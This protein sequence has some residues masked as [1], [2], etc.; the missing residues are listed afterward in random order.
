MTTAR[1]R[2]GKNFHKREE[3][4][5]IDEALEQDLGSGNQYILM[6]ILLL[7][8]VV[9]GTTFAWFCHAQQQTISHLTESLSGLQ[10]KIVKFQQVQEEMRTKNVELPVPEGFAERLEALEGAY[11]QAQKQ[12]AMAV[13]T[14]EQLKTFDLRSQVASMHTEMMVRLTD[15]ELTRVS[16]EDLSR[17]RDT[18]ESKGAEFQAVKEDL[19]GVASANRAL[20]GSVEG[21]SASF[22][23]T[24]AKVTEQAAL[25]DTLTAQLEAQ[26]A[27]L[28]G[29]KEMLTLHRAQLETSSK[30]IA[31]LKGL[32][33]VEQAKRTH[34]L[35]E[36]L[37]FVRRSLE[38]QSQ[39]ALSLHSSLRAQ[40]ESIQGQLETALDTPAP[41][42]PQLDQPAVLE[43]AQRD[44]G[45][46]ELQQEVD[47]ELGQEAEAPA[48][49]E[50]LEEK[51]AQEVQEQQL[52]QEAEAPV[53]QE[54]QEQEAE[55]EVQMELG[56]Q[57]QE[58]EQEEE[59]E[60]MVSEE[61][62][63]EQQ[64]EQEDLALEAKHRTEEE[65]EQQE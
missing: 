33:E 17:V 28:L 27:D 61:A 6:F 36:Q 26:V 8:L 2:K 23:G 25:V 45:E 19:S 14:A 55:Q 47:Q 3:N 52:G 53:D 38:D 37:T 16:A 7:L 5:F 54:V 42:T 24:V 35:G 59:E 18:V 57:E 43:E 58:A 41:E 21:L 49:Q 11:A 34:I 46:V 51:V 13:S 31:S 64:E 29:L 30:D 32:L 1:H 63:S 12:V 10:M 39:E 62:Y 9:G 15:L 56:V 60:V 44:D 20:A 22:A 65:A 4:H 48:D 50:V 40:L